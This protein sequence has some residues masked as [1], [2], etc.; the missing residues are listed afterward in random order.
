[1]AKN[2][3]FQAEDYFHKRVVLDASVVMKC[4][5]REKESE[6]VEKLLKMASKKDTTILSPPLIKFEIFNSAAK[7]LGDA[8]AA[9]QVFA[10]FKKIDLIVVEA[11]NKFTIEAI[12]KASEK[13]KV[14]FYDASYHA[15]AKDFDATFITADKEY[16]ESIDDKKDVV[17]ID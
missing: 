2:K 15:L 1:M 12:K 6:E 8:K 17:L 5:F 4:F 11:R 3:K 10:L 14:T 13:K 9:L 7:K 16:Y